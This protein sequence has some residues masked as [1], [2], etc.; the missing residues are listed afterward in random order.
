MANIECGRGHIY[1]TEL[2]TACPYCNRSVHT[3]AVPIGDSGKTLPPRNY[4][5]PAQAGTVPQISVV[6]DGKTLPPKSYGAPKSVLDDNKT[7]GEMKS[8]LGIDPVVG[9]L[10]CIEGAEVG[11]DWRLL[12]QINTVGRSSKMDVSISGDKTITDENHM[13]VAY[14]ERNN[15]FTLIPA[16]SKNIV[17]LNG[18]E[19][20][21][22]TE[23]S[24]YDEII[25][26]Q[27]KLLFIPFCGDRFD[28]NSLGVKDAANAAV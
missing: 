4:G 28:W 22:P 27:T 11:R 10:I 19:L 7:I 14:S 24:A 5:V 21:L 26:G 12:G 9:W 20:F 18:N 16:E 23:L 17:Y 2:Y 6:N 13:R 25:C 1:D 8:K 3:G 15:R